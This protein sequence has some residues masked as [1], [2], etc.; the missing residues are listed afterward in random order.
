MTEKYCVILE[1]TVGFG[2]IAGLSLLWAV[3]ACG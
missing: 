1:Y 2:V 3:M